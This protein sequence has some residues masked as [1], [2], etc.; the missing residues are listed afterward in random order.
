MTTGQE[1]R[2][3]DVLATLSNPE[4]AASVAETK[5]ALAQARADRDNVF[6]GVRQEQ[7]DRSAREVEIAEAN[8]TF[9]MQQ[10]GRSAITEKNFTSKQQLDQNTASLKKSEANVAS[11]RAAYARDKAGPTKEERACE[12]GN[13]NR[14]S[15]CGKAKAK[16]VDA[17]QG[18]KS[19]RL[20][21]FRARVAK[22]APLL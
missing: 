19:Y 11:L 7:V 2:K 3:G 20:G 18:G 10:Y 14:N 16:G 15:G 8:L 17:Y 21:R 6:A 13:P 4:L 22:T 5:A 1:V 9:A 12:I